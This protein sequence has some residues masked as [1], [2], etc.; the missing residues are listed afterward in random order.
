MELRRFDYVIVVADSCPQCGQRVIVTIIAPVQEFDS[1]IK[2]FCVD[3][4][5][6][7]RDF[8]TVAKKP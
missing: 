6:W 4:G 1:T 8:Q 7:Y 3:H 2:F 5:A